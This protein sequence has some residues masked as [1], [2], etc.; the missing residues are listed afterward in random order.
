MVGVATPFL[1]RKIYG[2]ARDAGL[3]RLISSRSC[4]E[5]EELLQAIE[6]SATCCPVA[7]VARTS[8]VRPPTLIMLSGSHLRGSVQMT[9]GEPISR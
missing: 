2:Y 7:E 1:T 5:R 8:D 3:D 6:N 4:R 9:P